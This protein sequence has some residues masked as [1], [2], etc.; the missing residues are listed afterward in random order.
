ML[1]R[2]VISTTRLKQSNNNLNFL[3]AAQLGCFFYLGLRGVSVDIQYIKD[4]PLGKKGQFASVQ[5][6]EGKALIL[7]GFAKE[8]SV[9]RNLNGTPIVDNFGSLVLEV[10][11]AKKGGKNSK[12]G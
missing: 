11:A 5:D 10:E 12:K 1:M 6:Y 3:K 7:L 9:I 4:A 8:L 2:L